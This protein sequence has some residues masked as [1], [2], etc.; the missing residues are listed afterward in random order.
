MG[1]ETEL[2]RSRIGLFA[3]GK[4][5]LR[6][7]CV[8][9]LH[10]TKGLLVFAVI[11]VLLHIGGVESNPG[12]NRDDEIFD[13]IERMSDRLMNEMKDV[14][15]DL[16]S[17]KQE[18][19]LMKGMC[20][21]LNETC[22]ELRRS[23]EALGNRIGKMETRMNELE[24]QREADQ[25]SLDSVHCENENLKRIVSGLEEEIDMLESRSRRD[26]LRF[27][28]MKEEGRD[29]FEQCATS[30]VDVLNKF[31][32]FKSWTLEDIARAHR[33]G[34][35]QNA[36]NPRHLIAKF[37]KW[38]DVNSILKDRE[39][40]EKLRQIGVRIGTDL[41]RRQAKQME[42]AQAEGKFAYFKHGRLVVEE[43]RS[44]HGQENRGERRREGRQERG[45]TDRDGAGKERPWTRSLT[46]SQSSSSSHRDS[47]SP[48]MSGRNS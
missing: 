45:S 20:D 8:R 11:T 12:P 23:H 25:D 30:V 43:R 7:S 13:R 42:K 46:A 48:E 21:K 1:I 10:F 16:R 47:R 28:G 34:R 15:S 4:L 22:Q 2:Y 36:R 29:S 31:F 39:A 44:P 32:T 40:R 41:T 18:V 19:E 38:N 37:T 27:F 35:T 3:G 14:K 33:V 17:L 5:H 26:N 24:M 6:A 9:G